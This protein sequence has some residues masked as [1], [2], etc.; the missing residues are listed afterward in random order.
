MNKVELMIRPFQLGEDT[1]VIYQGKHNPVGDSSSRLF[2]D[3]KAEFVEI[4][5]KGS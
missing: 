1:T 5:E 2:L 3:S 4:F